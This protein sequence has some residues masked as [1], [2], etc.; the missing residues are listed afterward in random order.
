[1]HSLRCFIFIGIST[2]SA[3]EDGDKDAIRLIIISYPFQPTPPARTETT[4][5]TSPNS[6]LLIS[7]HSAREDGDLKSHRLF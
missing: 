5:L 4:V 6:S 1:M 3:R 2:H 7:T